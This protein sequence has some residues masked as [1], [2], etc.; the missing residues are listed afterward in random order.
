MPS[1]LCCHMALILLLCLG[2]VPTGAAESP[3]TVQLQL[4]PK[5]E[6]DCALQYLFETPYMKQRPGNAALLYPTAVAQLTLMSNNDPT[7]DRKTFQKWRDM[8]IKELPIEEV[9]SAVDRFHRAISR[10]DLASRCEW[11]LWESPVR[12]EGFSYLLPHL[13]EYR[14]LGEILALKARLQIHDGQLDEAMDTLRIGL[15]MA[16]DIARGPSLIEGLV[17]MAIATT[18]AGEIEDL[19]QSPEAPNLYWAL[20][21]LPTPLI[22]MR[23]GIQMESD[24]L[25]AEMPE[26]ERLEEEVLS[27]EQAAAIWNQA[28]TFLSDMDGYPDR[29]TR[30][31]AGLAGAL[32]VYPEAKARLI[33][34]GRDAQEV[35]SLPPLYV[36]LLDQFRQYRIIRD[37]QFK[38][39]YLPYWQARK[40]FDRFNVQMAQRASAQD[41]SHKAMNPFLAML[42]SI[43]RITFLSGR[44]QRHFAMLRTIEAIRMYAADHDG[45]LPQSLDDITAVSIP[46]DPLRGKPFGYEVTGRNIILE[47]P[48]PLKE[49]PREGR[50]YEI[51]M[52]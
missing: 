8:P 33:E 11:C 19:I 35:E 47:A 16:R 45:A 24:T 49:S 36:V 23:A 40:G 15:T 22:D 46:M 41:D 7:P 31:A 26:L 13:S 50:R 17:G 1:K 44:L 51:T 39:M 3:Q 2:W 25:Y 20:T 21:V 52:R 14:Q 28:I 12:E 38:W 29:L 42:P 9:R 30:A 4:Q 34:R 27:D 43:Q 48:A 10:L 6:P 32:K 5:A 37:M 18:M